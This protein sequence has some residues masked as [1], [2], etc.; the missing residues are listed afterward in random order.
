M[1]PSFGALK[2]TQQLQWT[3]MGRWGAVL[4]ITGPLLVQRKRFQR[5]AAG[6]IWE[7]GVEGWG[8]GGGHL[9]L[10]Q[11]EVFSIHAAACGAAQR[12][13]LHRQRESALAA[14]LLKGKPEP[15]CR[16]LI[17]LEGRVR[18]DQISPSSDWSS[19]PACPIRFAIHS[20]TAGLIKSVFNWIRSSR[21]GALPSVFN[22]RS[23]VK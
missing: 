20:P 9:S 11:G 17:L 14:I 4:H 10:W 12:N 16:H 5:L 13:S 19:G 2:V 22:P 3:L 6:A 8:G 21:D 18:S 1:R 15:L 23:S 7:G